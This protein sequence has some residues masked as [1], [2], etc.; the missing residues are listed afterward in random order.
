[1][2]IRISLALTAGLM[3]G[4]LPHAAVAQTAFFGQP[5]DTIA[6]T[7]NTTL[8]DAYTIEAY[9]YATATTAASEGVPRP[10]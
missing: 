9:V 1:M 10:G 2:H 3:I 8:G 7:G 6:L 5:T 4:S